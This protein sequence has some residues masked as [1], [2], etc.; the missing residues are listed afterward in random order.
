MRRNDEDDR[1]RRRAAQ[2]LSGLLLGFC[3]ASVGLVSGL[4][5]GRAT[6]ELVGPLP[7]CRRPAAGSPS[8]PAAGGSPDPWRMKSDRGRR[9]RFVVTRSG[10]GRWKL[11]RSC[12]RPGMAGSGSLASV[13][14]C[15][16]INDGARRD[17]GGGAR[18]GVMVAEG[19]RAHGR[20]C[21]PWLGFVRPGM[22]M[23]G[24]WSKLGG[25]AR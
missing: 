20:G 25:G 22:G 11:G 24:G 16:V 12:P 14:D 8:R 13:G 4:L 19:D 2:S 17:L 23:A 7:N 10:G 3:R 18:S 21:S 9:R 1:T 15:T 5:S 6:N